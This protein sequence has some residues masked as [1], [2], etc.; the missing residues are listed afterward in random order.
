[1]FYHIFNFVASRG[2]RPTE[3]VQQESEAIKAMAA[4]N[5]HP[6]QPIVKAV[7]T[8]GEKPRV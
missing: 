8:V 3:E 7:G 2:Q 4:T 5:F 1:M 6:V